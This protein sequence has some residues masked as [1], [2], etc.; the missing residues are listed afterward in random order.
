MSG[1]YYAVIM[2]GGGGTRLWPLSRKARPKQLLRIIEQR[3][4]FQMAVDRLEGLF[5]PKQIFVVT[6]PEQFRELH[7]QCPQIPEENFLLEPV[8]RGTAAVVGLAAVCLA[9]LDPEAVMAVLTADHYIGNQEWFHRLLQVAETVARQNYLVTIGIHPTFAATGYGYIQQ[10]KLQGNYQGVD[11]YHV[12]RFKEKPD[13]FQAQV[14][15]ARGDHTWNSGMFIWRVDR[16]RQEIR[17]HLPQLEKALNEIEAHWGKPTYS[18]VLEQQWRGLTPETIDYGIMERARDVVVIPAGA[19]KWSDVGSWDSLFDVL[20]SDAHGNI[21][22][23]GRHFSLNTRH[24][25]VY[26]TEEHRLIVTIGVRDLVVVDTGDV[27]LIVRKDEAQKVRQVVE[28]LRES[29]EDYI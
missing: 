6:V 14:M 1:S 12:I 4:L 27:L 11:V 20:P 18:A 13:E 9:R 16:I 8:P 22:I 21:V 29:G 25:L 26:V 23:G 28:L 2:A 17:E 15:L 10:G 7:E 5:D 3:S 19:L 24:S